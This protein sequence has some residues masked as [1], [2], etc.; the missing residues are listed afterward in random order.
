MSEPIST[1]LARESVA[2][3]LGR[4]YRQARIL[5]RLLL[6][7]EQAEA[8]G[9]SVANVAALPSPDAAKAKGGRD[10]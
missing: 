5:R 2:E 10:A 4:L 6:I 3:N 9:L 8:Q 7:L 1:R